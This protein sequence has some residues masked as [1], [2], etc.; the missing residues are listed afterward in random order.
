M[1]LTRGNKKTRRTGGQKDTQS[2]SVAS[3]FAN[4][5]D[6]EE[7]DTDEIRAKENTQVSDDVIKAQ[8]DLEMQEAAFPL[9]Q[10]YKFQ[11]FLND[12]LNLCKFVQLMILAFIVNV[13]FYNKNDLF[14]EVHAA[15]GYNALGIVV[16]MFLSYVKRKDSYLDNPDVLPKPRYPEFNSI[17]AVILPMLLSALGDRR[18]LLINLSLGYFMV[19]YLAI[20]FKVLSAVAFFVVFNDDSL[21]PFM[22]MTGVVAFH[23]LSSTFL[24]SVS[25]EKKRA[26]GEEEENK[27]VSLTKPEIQLISVLIVDLVFGI[28]RGTQLNISLIILQKLFLGLVFALIVA[29]PVF[30]LYQHSRLV[31]FEALTAVVFTGVFIF[32]TDFQLSSH[33]NSKSSIIWLLHYIKDSKERTLI[34]TAWVGT[35]AIVI[36]SM[37]WFSECF[38]LNTRRKFWHILL[39]AMISYPALLREPELTAIS[40]FGMTIVLILVEFIRYNQFSVLGKFL[41]KSLRPFQDEKDLRGPLNLSYIFLI[42]GVSLP[43]ALDYCYEGKLTYKAYIG[44]ICLG[45]GDSSASVVG[46]TYGTLKWKGSTKSVQGTISFILFSFISFYILDAYMWPGCVKNWENLFVSCIIGGVLEGV[47]D[48]NDNFLIPCVVYISAYILDSSNF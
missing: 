37:F 22:Q 35:L 34:V 30:A 40:L 5:G 32:M 26:D 23:Y 24:S 8:A 4:D 36:P 29:Y 2:R 31:I 12:N 17:Y 16:A 1:R 20:M 19:D 10:I 18:L 48:L 6:F 27:N 15:V 3:I 21:V 45:V 14:W 39:M 41:H 42:I 7:G 13:F 44:L 47:G 25:S 43:I 28:Q 33:L 46:K 11:D 9:K 38:S